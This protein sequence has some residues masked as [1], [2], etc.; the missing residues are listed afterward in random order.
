VKVDAVYQALRRVE[1]R[2][3]EKVA[4]PGPVDSFL[5]AGVYWWRLETPGGNVAI[6]CMAD[7]PTSS[8]KKAVR[9]GARKRRAQP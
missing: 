1:K 6:I 7:A 4:R 5:L 2:G 8:S 3:S 9:P